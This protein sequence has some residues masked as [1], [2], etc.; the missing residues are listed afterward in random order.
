MP[1][2]PLP[3][4]E[5]ERLE[6]LHRYE[7]LD[8]PPEKEL[9]DLVHLASYICRTPIAIISLVDS[10]RQ[11]F[12]S[13]IGLTATET[14]RFIAFCSH[15]ILGP[16]LMIV[17][18]AL[19]DERFAD[20]PLV[21]GD[22]R[23]R[24]YCGAPLTTPDG[25]R[26]GTLSVIDHVPRTLTEEQQGALLVLSRQVIEHLLLSR[27]LKELS[28]TYSSLSQTHESLRQSEEKFR[29]L[30]ESS[31]SAIFIYR[32]NRILYA[33]EAAAIISGYP[34]EELLAM[35]MWK[36]GHPDFLPLLK[37]RALAA[38][39]GE[40]TPVRYEFKIIRKDGQER[41]LD[42]TAATI[43]HVGQPA[44]LAT[45]Y[46]ITE[47]KR[48][49]V[50]MR[51]Q[52]RMLELIAVGTP[53]HETL[54]TLVRSIETQSDGMLASILL[55]DADGVHVRCAAAPSLPASFIRAVDGQPIGPSAGSCGT[56]AFRR[57]T[58]IVEDIATDPLW[59]NYRDHALPHGLRACWS[60]PIFDNQR[61]VL[62]TFALYFRTPGQ[63]TPRHIRLVGMA[64]HTAS[65]AI[66]R[67][68]KL[69]ALVEREAQL[70]LFV[71]HSPAALAMFDRD[72]RYLT[73]SRRWMIDYKL[74]CGPLTGRSHYEVFPDIPQRWKEIHRRCLAGEVEESEEDIF[75]HADGRTDWLRWK[76]RPWRTASGD[77]GGIVIFTEDITERKQS[78]AALRRNGERLQQA[79]ADT[80]DR[81]RLLQAIFDSEPECVK[82]LDSQGLLLSMNRAGLEMLEA[83]SFS[84]LKNHSIYPLVTEEYREPF[85]RLTE[86]VFQNESG[87]LEF[88]MVGLKGTRRI[89]ETHACPLRDQKGAVQALLGITRDITDKRRVDEALRVSE[90]RLQAILDNSPL[91]V[92]LKDRDGRYLFVNRMFERR[93][94]LSCD[95]VVGKTDDDL[96]SP[97]QASAFRKN[98]LEVLCTGLS[99]EFEEAAHYEDGGHISIVVKFP[100]RDAKEEIYAIGG[101]VTDITERKKAEEQAHR[102]QQVFERAM[103]GLA[104]GNITD[105]TFLA[106]NEAFASQRGYRVDELIGQSILSIYAPD[107]RDEMKARLPE[108]DRHGHL[109]FES[110]HQRKDGTTFPVLMEVTV[111]KDTQG[112]PISRVAYALDITDRNRAYEALQESYHHLQALSREVQI[113]Q[114]RERS[115]LSRELH[116]EFGQL[117]SALKFD[118]NDIAGTLL[119][120]RSPAASVL[121]KRAKM[122]ADTVDRLFS[123]LREMVAALRPAVLEE[124]GLVPAVQT[125]AAEMQERSSLHCHVVADQEIAE[126]SFGV[127]LEGAFFRIAQ[128]LLTNVARHAKATSAT[129]SLRGTDGWMTLVVEDDGK[130]FR[131]RS[132]LRK[133]RFGLRGVQERAELL[134]GNVEIRSEPGSGTVVTVRLPVK[135]PLPEEGAVAFPQLQKPVTAKKRGRHGKEV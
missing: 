96:F 9:D 106:V 90:A 29:T 125:I 124:L 50:A 76:I 107:M 94:D 55:L 128:E 64:T 54:D 113:T 95:Q 103:F 118:L 78:E 17:P 116:D 41:W 117:L 15:T 22:P 49:E 69:K 79:L 58:V 115:R 19:A 11:W 3:P 2:L 91:I 65:I 63:P 119:K 40:E 13:K 133:G 10:D 80:S 48:G 35:D 14:S 34:V 57:E 82:L 16:D 73:V 126:Q 39:K 26:I 97:E 108:I 33:N 127:E 68:K 81:E 134:G 60:T 52:S 45:G 99:M 12:K 102:W 46:D 105:G 72:M 70:H 130:G 75:V 23:I 132:A 59:M 25:F 135:P 129:I 43:D 93:F 85:R 104:Y 100:V 44:W 61:Q 83:D 6:A 87:S 84:Q 28:L 32:D 71:E 38:Q 77:I 5:T 4:R 110:V 7:I 24:F 31:P 8:T 86:A 36:I 74:G 66:D 20:N 88:E 30:N 109:L 27:N 56:A 89:L 98:D 123:S 53:L 131:T 62:G 1:Q 122:A 92:F 112:N 67:D 120:I 42:F 47:R 21:T 101:F 111:I 121:R 18:D 37:A 51:I 114:E